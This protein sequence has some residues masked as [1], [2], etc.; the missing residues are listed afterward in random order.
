M[1]WIARNGDAAWMVQG[2]GDPSLIHTDPA[3]YTLVEV[4]GTECPDPRL[5]RHD[6]NSSTKLRSATVAEMAQYD[7]SVAATR[8]FTT[9][10]QKDV[11]ATCALIVRAR[12]GISAWNAL[13]IQQKVDA[14][15]AEADVW[16]AIREFIDDKV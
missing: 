6:A 14:T 13:T 7:A 1:Q 11:L 5:T 8:A 10:R 4:P 3:N 16:K 9:S 12:L 15:I 2:F